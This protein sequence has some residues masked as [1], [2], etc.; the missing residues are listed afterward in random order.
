MQY[1]LEVGGDK[2]YVVSV[3]LNVSDDRV[4]SLEQTTLS[5]L[6]AHTSASV[7]EESSLNTETTFDKSKDSFKLVGD[8]LVEG[9]FCGGVGVKYG[10]SV[11]CGVLLKTGNGVKNGVPVGCGY[12]P[13][14]VV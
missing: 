12:P 8:G 9:V 10:V 3:K 7:R 6:T 1:K 14:I 5:Q 13:E 4:L 11:G 2:L